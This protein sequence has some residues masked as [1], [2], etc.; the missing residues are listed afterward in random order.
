[1]R[2]RLKEGVRREIKPKR[3]ATMSWTHFALWRPVWRQPAAVTAATCG[4]AG[5]SAAAAAKAVMGNLSIRGAL[6]RRCGSPIRVGAMI[7]S[8]RFVAAVAMA[9]EG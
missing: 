8:C 3:Q 6:K 2:Q 7:P 5:F 1:M 4:G 9:S